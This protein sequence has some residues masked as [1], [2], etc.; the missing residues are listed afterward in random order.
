MIQA[1]QIRPGMVIKFEGELYSVMTSVHRTP[2]NLRAFVQ[3][4]MRSLKNSNLLDHRF[5]S[6]DRVEKAQLDSHDMEFLYVEGDSLVFMNI[7]TYDQINISKEMLGDAAGYITP[8]L[9][10]S[11]EFYEGTPIGVDLPP[12]VEL[13]IVETEPGIKGATVS[14]VGKPAKMETGIIVNVPAFIE[15]GEVIRVSTADGS[16]LSRA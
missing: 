15:E 5:A 12:A 2:G 8:N 9:K 14:N 3:T 13:K 11:V 6:T 1:T 10:I 4:R 7:E 16:Y